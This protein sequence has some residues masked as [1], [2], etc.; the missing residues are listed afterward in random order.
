VGGI[1]DVVT[2]G[3]TGILV[4]PADARALGEA[5]LRVYQNREESGKMAQKAKEMVWKDYSFTRTIERTEEVY[6]SL[7]ESGSQREM[8]T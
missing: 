6:K 5:I 4:P 7:L 8:L 1:E 3:Q 2:N